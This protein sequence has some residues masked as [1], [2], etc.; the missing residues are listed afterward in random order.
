MK[1]AR[2]VLES[3]PS[4]AIYS[5][6]P[7]ASVYAALQLM[8]EKGIGA[9]LVIEHGEIKGILSERDYARKV[10]LMQR[11]SRETLVRDIMTTAVIYVSANQ[12]T[13][14][15]MALM[16]RHRL[17]HLPVMQ[18]DELIGMLSIGDLVKDIISEQQFIIEQLEHYITGGGH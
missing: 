9:L 5:I 4:Q 12:T 16:T 13:D 18:G 7:T 1:T 10:I 6:P 17:R 11:T 2:Q 15:C 3:K 14:E 8:A